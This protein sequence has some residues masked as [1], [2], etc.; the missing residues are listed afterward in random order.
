M[1]GC[2]WKSQ[3]LATEFAAALTTALQTHIMDKHPVITAGAASSHGR[4][5]NNDG[6]GNDISAK[7]EKLNRPE[8]IKGCTSE[9]WGYFSSMWTSYTTATKL[10]GHDEDPALGLL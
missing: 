1:A 2:D 10:S 7:P 9:D 6:S 5:G 8:I 4:R 3:D